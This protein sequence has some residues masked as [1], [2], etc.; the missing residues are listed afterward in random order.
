MSSVVSSVETRYKFASEV[1]YTTLTLLQLKMFEQKGGLWAAKAREEIS[2][3]N[4]K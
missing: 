1:P 2:K 4:N 3:R